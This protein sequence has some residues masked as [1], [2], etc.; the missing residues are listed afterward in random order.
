MSVAFFT[1]VLMTAGIIELPAARQS[2][3]NTLL[4]VGTFHKD[5]VT[6]STGAG[7]MAL[8]FSGHQ[9]SLNK[10]SI[11]VAIVEDPVMDPAGVKTGKQVRTRPVVRPMI[12]IDSAIGLNSGPVVGKGWGGRIMTGEAGD[13]PGFSGI[14]LE[15]RKS[16]RLAL[17]KAQLSL[18]AS[19]RDSGPRGGL[20]GGYRLV[21]TDGKGSSQIL[22]NFD[23]VGWDGTFP[24]LIWTGDLDRDGKLDI[25]IDAKDDENVSRLHLYLSSKRKSKQLLRLVGSFDTLGC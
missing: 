2:T 20:N 23:A 8:V 25:L 18:R 10:V 19:L 14:S 1:A 17:G 4:R 5:E 15:P 13:I 22:L 11:D 16:V 9:F 21:L 24:T 7:Y 6:S 12:L 3:K